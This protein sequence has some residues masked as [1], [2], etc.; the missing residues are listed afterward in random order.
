MTLVRII[1]ITPSAQYGLEG[2]PINPFTSY[3][4]LVHSLGVNDKGQREY[5]VDVDE[6]NLDDPSHPD[7]GV[8]EGWDWKTYQTP[9]VPARQHFG[10]MRVNYTSVEWVMKNGGGWSLTAKPEKRSN[11]TSHKDAANALWEIK[12][13]YSWADDALTVVPLAKH[14]VTGQ[15]PS[16]TYEEG[17]TFVV[18]RESEIHQD[19]YSVCTTEYVKDLYD[20]LDGFDLD[21]DKR[22][23]FTTDIDERWEFDTFD[24]AREAVGYLG[25]KYLVVVPIAPKPLSPAAIA[26]AENL[27]SERIRVNKEDEPDPS[28]RPCLC[29][30]GKPYKRCNAF[31]L[32]CG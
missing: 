15:L 16:P 22:G 9:V 6:T 30:S 23:D 13:L 21:K 8:P 18:L 7:P 27:V 20:R 25:D 11:Y 29:G 28:N 10:I 19:G 24:E 26:S 5:L 12:R 31:D 14:S 17:T 4:E 1:E 2:Q 32:A 3:C